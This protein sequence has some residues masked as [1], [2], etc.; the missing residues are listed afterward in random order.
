M[1]LAESGRGWKPS[2][3]VQAKRLVGYQGRIPRCLTRCV[4]APR[5]ANLIW[6]CVSLAARDFHSPLA[7][8]AF[9]FDRMT[10]CENLD[11]HACGTA[12]L[13]DR[14]DGRRAGRSCFTNHPAPCF[15]L[16]AG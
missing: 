8:H 6:P 12:L 2:P 15:D 10:S 1:S 14:G 3:P 13:A 4:P 9:L 5:A 11:E 7:K 16:G